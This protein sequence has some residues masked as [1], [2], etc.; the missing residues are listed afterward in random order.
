MKKK[1]LII[2][3]LIFIFAI[4]L[5]F[6][7]YYTDELVENVLEVKK[8]IKSKV[9][10]KNSSNSNTFED[11]QYKGIDLNGNRYIIDSKFAEFDLSKPELIKM[12]V[13]NATFYF[14][15]GSVLKVVGDWG[16]YNNKSFDMEFRDNIKAVYLD[17]NL[18]SDN[19]DYYNSK[20][21]LTIYGNVVTE[22]VQGTTKSDK[23]VVDLKDQ[24][25]NMTMYNNEQVNVKLKKKWE[26]VLE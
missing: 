24:T 9:I 4:S 2:Q 17:N 11:I 22:S 21:L 26:K 6:T 13:M 16:T 19:L 23:L 20:N 15:D 5:L 1:I 10:T 25:L 7:T 3:I 12:R 14:K 18:Y 8:P